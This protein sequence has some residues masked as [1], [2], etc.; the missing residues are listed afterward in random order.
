MAQEAKNIAHNITLRHAPVEER[1]TGYINNQVF[2]AIRGTGKKWWEV[3]DGVVKD[4][5]ETH[6]S[7][8]TLI[9]PNVAVK[10]ENQTQVAAQLESI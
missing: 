10:K 5:N 6:V 4:Y 3:V 7:R 2:N 1:M 8:N 9:T